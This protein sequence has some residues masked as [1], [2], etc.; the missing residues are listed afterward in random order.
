[1]PQRPGEALWRS[2]G[3]QCADPVASAPGFLGIARHRVARSP[4]IGVG[5]P[6]WPGPP[7]LPGRLRH[8][9]QSGMIRQGP[10]EVHVR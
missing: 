4:R 8:D 10:C 2:D 5:R 9:G 6:G 1:M 3:V 7:S